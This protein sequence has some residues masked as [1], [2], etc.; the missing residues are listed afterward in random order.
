M[1]VG[2]KIKSIEKKYLREDL[3]NFEVGDTLKMKVKVREAE[4]VRMHPF[5]GTVIRITGG[6]VGATFTVRKMS[7]GE[8]IEKTFP[9]HS[10]TIESIEIVSKGR[11]RRAKLYYLRDRVGKRARVKKRQV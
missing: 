10:P 6:G 11:I 7:F 9:L 2:E 8:G 5:N 1:N 3:P 4:K